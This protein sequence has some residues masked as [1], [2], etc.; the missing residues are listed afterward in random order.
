MLPSP[1][2]R[3]HQKSQESA[4][5]S[6]PS[7]SFQRLADTTIRQRSGDHGKEFL[8]WITS[9]QPPVPGQ[10]KQGC[11]SPAVEMS[12]KLPHVLLASS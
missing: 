2:E 11:E 7:G 4:H 8:D 3:L 6:Q 10:L 5:D 1:M 9:F 12:L